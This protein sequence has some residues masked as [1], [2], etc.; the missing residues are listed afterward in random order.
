MNI[1]TEG[2]GDLGETQEESVCH[3]LPERVSSRRLSQPQRNGSDT[4]G[5]EQGD[6]QQKTRDRGTMGSSRVGR[7]G[8]G[9]GAGTGAGR[10]RA[11]R[12]GGSAVGT[13][14]GLLGVRLAQRR[15]RGAGVN[16]PAVRGRGRT[17]HGRDGPSLLLVVGKRHSRGAEC[18]PL[19]LEVIK[20]GLHGGRRALAGEAIFDIGT[21]GR[22]RVNRGPITD[23]SVVVALLNP[24][25]DHRTGPRSSHLGAKD[26]GL[27]T[28]VP[29]LGGVAASFR[30]EDGNIVGGSIQLQLVVT[31]AFVGVLAAPLIGI[32]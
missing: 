30:E 1:D 28:K 15:K 16:R 14:L 18:R 24:L 17:L 21:R 26:G 6:G 13:P 31:R 12:L 29:R 5:K 11:G 4:S 9:A 3:H 2:E 23:N 27:V 22:R 19:S 20:I 7:I 25:V 32:Q 8:R 10:C